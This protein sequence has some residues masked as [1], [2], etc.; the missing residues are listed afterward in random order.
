MRKELYLAIIERLK[1][2][3]PQLTHFDLWN[4]NV[5]FIEQENVFSMPAVFI[6]FKPIQWKTLQMDVQQAEI[7]FALHVVT[8]WEAPAND[9]SDYQ[10]QA[11]EVFDL[12]DEVAAALHLMQGKGFQG[13]RRIESATNHNH[14]QIRE[15]IEVFTIQVAGRL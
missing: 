12:L 6:E 2:R 5:A 14:G 15:D 4:Q 10:A 7:T 11:L 8:A 1:E 13:C 9:G 3:I